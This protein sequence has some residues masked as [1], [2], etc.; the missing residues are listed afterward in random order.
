MTPWATVGAKKIL[1]V[2]Q[3]YALSTKFHYGWVIDHPFDRNFY[4]WTLTHEPTLLDRGTYVKLCF[5]SDAWGVSTD[6]SQ[7]SYNEDE[8]RRK[9]NELDEESVNKA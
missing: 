3:T 1:K 4:A 5:K 8:N 6:Y 9:G 2:T 7:W